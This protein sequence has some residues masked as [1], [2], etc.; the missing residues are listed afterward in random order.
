[1]LR[2]AA[3]FFFLRLIFAAAAYFA[4]ML[5]H[6]HVDIAAIFFCRHTPILFSPPLS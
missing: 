3:F 4:D 1:M 5:R 6:C 2:H